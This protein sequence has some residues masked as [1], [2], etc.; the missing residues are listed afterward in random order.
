M[1]TIIVMFFAFIQVNETNFRTFSSL[2]WL[3]FSINR[4]FLFL[5]CR[6]KLNFVR[7]LSLVNFVSNVAE[8]FID[9]IFLFLFIILLCLDVLL[10]FCSKK[11]DFVVRYFCFQ[12][13]EIKKL[14][15]N[16]F[17]SNFRC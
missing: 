17:S 16:V 9:V 3:K 4:R 12:L 10:L 11:N 8:K 13:R 2:L 7:R 1:I 14:Q 15:L 6:V 5:N